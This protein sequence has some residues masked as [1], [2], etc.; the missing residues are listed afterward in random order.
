MNTHIVDFEKASPHVVLGVQP[1]LLCVVDDEQIMGDILKEIA[2]E[3]QF[4]YKYYSSGE[5]ALNEFKKNP[6][7][8]VFLDVNMPGMNGLEVLQELKRFSPESKVVIRLWII[9]ILLALLTLSTFK[10]R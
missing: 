4:D 10:V 2:I 8:L 5:Q 6:P 3:R 7:A 1:N 9:G